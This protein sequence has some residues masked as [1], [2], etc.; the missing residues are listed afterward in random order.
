VTSLLV[1]PVPVH[2]PFTSAAHSLVATIAVI[3]RALHAGE[4]SPMCSLMH[5]ATRPSPGS[6]FVQYAL[7]STAQGRGRGCAV[8]VVPA[9]NSKAKPSGRIDFLGIFHS[10]VICNQSTATSDNHSSCGRIET[11]WSAP[12]VVDAAPTDRGI[13]MQ[14]L[15]VCD[16]HKQ[17]SVAAQRSVCRKQRRFTTQNA[18]FSIY[19]LQVSKNCGNQ[20]RD[21]RVD[22]HRPLQDRIRRSS[23]HHIE[24]A[25][26]MRRRSFITLLAGAAAGRSPARVPARGTPP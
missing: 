26:D 14:D 20:L 17:I 9:T 11:M 23:I 4:K 22:G 13:P 6:I 21:G 5:A 25:V 19:G 7:I 18:L 15:P 10:P 8:A 16:S 24:D 3:S 1:W 2:C 12:G